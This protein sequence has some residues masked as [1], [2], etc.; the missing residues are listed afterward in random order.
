VL[1]DRLS[2]FAKV[3]ELSL[4]FEAWLNKDHYTE[5]EMELVEQFIP[6][7]IG[8]VVNA[9]KCEEGNGMKL[10]KVHLTGHFPLMIQL[11]D[12]PKNID[13]S[14]PESNL[15]IKVKDEA[16]LTWMQAMNFELH[17]AQKDYE[18]IVLHAGASEIVHLGKST[19]LP[20]YIANL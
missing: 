4:Q 18:T 17:T 14:G 12:K 16:K 10:I 3:F 7:F 15:K 2:E 5:F 19:I 13:G 11:Y 1:A 20:K 8:T 9:V 6:F